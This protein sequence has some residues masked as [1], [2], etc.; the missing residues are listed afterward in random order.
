MVE[1]AKILG[2]VEFAAEEAVSS[3]KHGMFSIFPDL[4]QRR[5]M[6]HMNSTDA[7]ARLVND[8][9]DTQ[10]MSPDAEG[11]ESASSENPGI[12]IE[13]DAR[14]ARARLQKSSLSLQELRALRR[15][16]AWRLHPD[17]TP[18]AD[19]AAAAGAMAELNARIDALIE[20]KNRKSRR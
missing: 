2:E 6:E 9:Y 19:R 5:A 17:R 16:F 8:L 10:S 11:G 14:R 1:F 18:S 4:G 12:S 20:K 7:R 3:A 15:D 13:Q